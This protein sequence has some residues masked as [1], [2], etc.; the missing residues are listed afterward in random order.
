MSTFA[1][2]M[3]TEMRNLILCALLLLTSTPTWATI[4]RV[5]SKA[6]FTGSGR[7]CAATFTTDPAAHDLIAVWT[8]WK[9]STATASVGDSQGNTFSNAVGPTTQST[10][11]VNSQIFFAKNVA[12]SGA[13]TVTVTVTYSASATTCSVVIAEYTGLDQ[14]SPLDVTSANTGAGTTL[15]SNVAT[16]TFV[17]E[18]VFGAGSVSAGTASPGN[19]F[20]SIQ[21]S[22]GSIAEDNVLISNAQQRATAA[23]SSSGN[24]VMQLATF[25]D[26]STSWSGTT[27]FSGDVYF[28]SGVPWYDVKAFGAVCDGVTDDTTAITAAISSW[29]GN[30][31]GNTSSAG[32]L[33]FPRSANPCKFNGN[34]FN[35]P[36]NKGWLYVLMDNGFL[37]T[38]PVTPTSLTAFV[39]R[40]GNFQGLGGTAN[41][42][43]N[44][45]WMPATNILE[46]LNISGNG[47]GFYFEGVNFENHSASSTVSPVH[48]HAIAG[49][50]PA[51]INFVNC[52]I[53]SNSTNAAVLFDA[54]STTGPAGFGVFFRDTAIAVSAAAAASSVMAI[55]TGNFHFIGGSI[56]GGSVVFKNTGAASAGGASF[57]H[58][59]SEGLNNQD[60]LVLDTS[61]GGGVVETDFILKFVALADTVGSVYMVKGIGTGNRGI[62]IEMSPEG[63]IGT[64]II[65]PATTNPQGLVGVHCKGAGCDAIA[66]AVSAGT[67]VG[68]NVYP[69][70]ARP[71]T[72]GYNL[73]FIPSLAVVGGMTA[74]LKTVSTTYTLTY[75]DNWV[76]VTGTTTIT[77]PH[78]P[79]QT[80]S[81]QNV[82]HLFNS[83]SGTVTISCDS[84]NINGAASITLA[85]NVGK[86][87]TTD[88]TNCFA[89]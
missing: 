57:D 32:V 33:Y 52:Q 47:S 30:L 86:S 46:A 59:L 25:R 26:S 79:W 64:G 72:F 71:V 34:V 40:G 36:H 20:G 61:A 4:L 78:A 70:N 41:L 18:L 54:D 16:P 58:V 1:Q 42:A 29:N 49:A 5:Q 21:A 69:T 75:A 22:G 19:G 17:N 51:F 89:H 37:L 85:P 43:P 2:T 48:F 60:F 35:V 27:T 9:P 56:Y 11:G 84:G 7:T 55:N 12:G 80:G 77:V 67:V 10:S 63:N 14:I 39:G 8:T 73:P 15:D 87:V 68:L 6:N 24:W 31:F 82:W 3:E 50:G 76:N 88:G 45:T 44:V 23:A 62:N 13:D 53:N 74:T 83:G 81:P 28:K 66:A 65:D 38:G